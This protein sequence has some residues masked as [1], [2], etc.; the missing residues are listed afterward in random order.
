MEGYVQGDHVGLRIQRRQINILDAKIQRRGAWIGIERQQAHAKP[1]Q[2]TQRGDADFAGP[3]HP[4]CFTVHG[5][6][7]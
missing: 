4:G 3:D 5:K 6:A 2:N 7:G 1:F